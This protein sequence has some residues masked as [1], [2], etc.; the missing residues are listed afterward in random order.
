VPDMAAIAGWAKS[1]GVSGDGDVLLSEPA[2]LE[3]LEGEVDKAN[4]SFK[5]YERIREFLIDSEELSTTNGL[6][7][8]TLKL[9]RKTFNDKYA[10]TLDGLYPRSSEPAAPRASYIRE[11]KPAAKTA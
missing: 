10:K 1:N 7:T 8:Q 9:K 4:A 6:L 11:L 3:L 5:G 2:V